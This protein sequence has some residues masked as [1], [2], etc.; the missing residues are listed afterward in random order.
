LKSYPV[1]RYIDALAAPGA[2]LAGGVPTLAAIG[3][4]GTDLEALGVRAGMSGAAAR[5]A[6]FRARI[7]RYRDSRDF[8]AAKGPSYLSAHLRFGTV[9]IRDLAAYAY[10]RSLE[11][12][13]EGAATWL[14]ELIW[15]DFNAQILWH[16]PGVVTHAF[17]PEYDD[18]PFEN[19]RRS[20]PRGAKAAP[21]IR[22]SM[23]RCAR[24]TRR[25]TCTI[26]CG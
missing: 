24:S 21:D 11:P 26:G 15:R 6:D 25:A 19:D 1:D 5:V 17:K 2:A 20:S 13:G 9:P 12:G 16:N 23:R 4:R 22:S 7:D 10:R 14:S 18:L 3:S 8:P